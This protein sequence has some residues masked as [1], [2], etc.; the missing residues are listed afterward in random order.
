MELRGESIIV[1]RRGNIDVA[2]VAGA[3]SV[4]GSTPTAR[5]NSQCQ[6]SATVDEN[7]GVVSGPSCVS[8]GCKGS[9][10]L[11][12]IV[13]EGKTRYWCECQ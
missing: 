12:S 11:K 8:S 7:S 10:V 6:V 9:C 5:T 2:R 4:R 3:P 1:E 13:E